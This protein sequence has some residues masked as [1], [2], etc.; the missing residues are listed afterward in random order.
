MQKKH[1][2]FLPYDSI[3]V[4][5][6]ADREY[7]GYVLVFEQLVS[8]GHIVR[9]H[10]LANFRIA[11]PAIERYFVTTQV[12]I[13]IREHLHDLGEQISYEIVQRRLRRVQ[14]T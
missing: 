13:L 5:R 1:T 11:A 2:H 10:V 9:S 6:F 3:G 8:V 12:K 7:L 14:R 4:Q